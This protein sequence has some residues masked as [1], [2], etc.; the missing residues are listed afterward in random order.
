MNEQNYSPPKFE[1]PSKSVT[2]N[3][4]RQTRPPS[5]N[6]GIHAHREYNNLSSL[7]VRNPPQKAPVGFVNQ[8]QPK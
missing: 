5:N 2:P 3:L 7:E 1:M 4:K 8:L 6:P